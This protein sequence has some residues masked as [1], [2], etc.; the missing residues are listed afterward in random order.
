MSRAS[1]GRPTTRARRRRRNSGRGRRARRS[2]ARRPDG[3]PPRPAGAR[4]AAPVVGELHAS[5]TCLPGCPPGIALAHRD[6]EGLVARGVSL[7]GGGFPG[8]LRRDGRDAAGGPRGGVR[9]AVRRAVPGFYEPAAGETPAR[10]DARMAD[11]LDGFPALRTRYRQVEQSFPE[12]FAT[13]T[14]LF[15]QRFQ[16]FPPRP[17]RSGSCIRWGGW[18]AARARPAAGAT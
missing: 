14:L 18:M 16:G 5:R 4:V 3:R 7:A 11:A 17:C 8:L 12:A 13:A 2:G 15:G 10:F 9:E 1:S 6:G